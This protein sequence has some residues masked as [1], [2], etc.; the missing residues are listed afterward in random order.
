MMKIGIIYCLLPNLLNGAIIYRATDIRIGSAA[1]SPTSQQF[2]DL[3]INQDSIIDWRLG[4]GSSGIYSAVGINAPETT[5]FIYQAIEEDVAMGREIA[6]LPKDFLV[7]EEL[8]E[9]QFAF[10]SITDGLGG[11]LLSS[12]PSFESNGAFDFDP[13]YLAFQIEIN[14]NSHFGYA[15]IEEV[16][17]SGASI[18]ALAWNS[19]PGSPIRTGAIPEPSASLLSLSAVLLLTL[20]RWRKAV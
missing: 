8:T 17:A 13:A 1:S 3:D 2:V 12:S 15:L 19:E 6:P 11:V 16:T 9:P 7:S 10:L 14:G 20:H 5:K 18:S 4:T